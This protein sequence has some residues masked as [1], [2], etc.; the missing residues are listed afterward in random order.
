[1]KNKN[2]ASTCIALLFLTLASTAFAKSVH[3]DTLL[4][5]YNV[6]WDTPGPTSAQSMPLGNGDIGLNVWVEKSG[7]LVFYISK[8]DAWGGELDAQKDPWMKQGGVLMKLGAIHVSVSPNPL[9]KSTAFKQILKLKN[10]EIL[11][12]EGTGKSAVKLR[13]WVDANHPVIRVEALSGSPVS[14]NVKLDNW[15]AGQTD[16]VL[17]NQQNQ[18]A[19]YHHNSSTTDPHLANLTFGAIVKGKGLL[20]KDASTLQ[21]GKITSQLI[22]IY[23]LTAV[24]GSGEQWLS[25]LKQQVAEI[26]KLSLEQTRAAHQQWWGQFWNRSWV[27]LQGDEQA[28]Q[29]T[30][31]YVLQRFVTACAGRGTGPIKFNG[32]I[33]V[34]DNP[35]WKH[36]GKPDPQNADF[37]AWGGQYWF[38]NTRAMYWPRLMAG[39]FDMMLSL[40]NMYA[41]ILPANTAQV[42]QFYNH[43]GAYFAETS[44][45]WGG[46]QYMG[47][48]VKANYTGHYFTPILE[49]SMMMLDYYEYTGDT[50]FAKQTLLPIATAGLQFF[51]QHFGRDSTGKLLLDPDNSIEMFWKVHNPTPDIA[52]LHAVISRLLQLP[53]TIVDDKTKAQWQKLY[54]ILPPLP[55]SDDK[56]LLLPYTGPQTAKSFNSENPEL[57]AIYPFRLYGIGKP[58]LALA[59]NTFDARKQRSKGCWV[60]DPIQAAMLGEADVAKDYVSFAFTRKA[61]DLKFPAFWA[62]GNDYHPDEDNGGNG[63]NGLQQ[64]LLQTDG[65]KIILLPAWPAG[66]NAGFKL[67]APYNTT[68]E[69]KVVDGKL[70][71]LKVTPASR[72]A[73]VIDMSKK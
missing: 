6:T 31:G 18:V 58:D 45:F 66:W 35:S 37:R 63:E 39:D 71:N 28:K 60:Q 69:G 40:F 7:D 11:V 4:S 9:A 68:V 47:P 57:Y 42:K 29:V 54:S 51:D 10:G 25:K 38:Q 5:Q 67:N 14:V 33:F 62:S 48:D 65:K 16:T 13:V 34:V 8:T 55:V 26:E 56:K 21:S 17:N 73:D 24:A 61:P 20:S 64:M 43:G 59:R 30:Q 50:K 72:A 19:W 36:D 53:A 3:Q 70:Q 15:R 49:L 27:F 12:Q 23:P 52:A 32:S 46:L 22:S 1:M 44:P 41:K 2:L